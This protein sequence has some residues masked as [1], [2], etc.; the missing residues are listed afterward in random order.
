MSCLQIPG[1]SIVFAICFSLILPV[2]SAVADDKVYTLSYSP[3]TLFHQLV[4]DRVRVVYEKAGLKAE[5]IPL[6]HN[7]SL[8]SAN[9][10][11]VDGDVGR[12]P[13]VEDKFTNLVRVDAQ[14][15]SLN[16][17]AYTVRD[18]ITTYSEDLLTKYK[19]GYVLGVR[20]PEKKMQAIGGGVTARD[21]DALVEMLLEGRVDLI[22]AT[23][24]SAETVLKKLGDRGQ[25][26]RRLD[27]YVFTAPIYH[28]VN[29][30][31][32][33]IVPRLEKAV[34]EL[35]DEGYWDD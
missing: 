20:W 32:S 5:F 11:R 2:Q 13:S 1:L 27:P 19:V 25:V 30:K 9:E 3:G 33:D 8:L 31:N 14:L 35:M 10:G 4:R 29:R 22:L 24:A 7:R 21:Y 18:D 17:A 28:Y 16:G 15:M 34:R 26:A 6:P 12:V 23:E